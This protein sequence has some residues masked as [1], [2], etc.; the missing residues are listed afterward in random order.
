MPLPRT[1]SQWIVKM[2]R[3]PFI[4]MNRLF[5]PVTGLRHVAWKT[6][7]GRL[8]PFLSELAP[9]LGDIR[10]FLRWCASRYTVDGS[11][12]LHQLRL[13][14]YPT[15]YKV[16]YIPRAVFFRI[17]EPSTGISYLFMKLF[18]FWGGLCLT[19]GGVGLT[20]HNFISP[21][22]LQPKS[23]EVH[24]KVAPPKRKRDLYHMAEACASGGA[25]VMVGN[26]TKVD[27]GWW[28]FFCRG[29]T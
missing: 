24:L 8:I 15:I 9:F 6:V 19:L 22:S 2:T 7:L 27:P 14:V 20:S 4:K 5:I 16:L 11:E 23:R 12:I 21:K 26:S 13:V 17:S 25:W 3:L 28:C 18:Y 1:G 29:W 10:S